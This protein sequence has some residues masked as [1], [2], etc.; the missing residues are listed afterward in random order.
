MKISVSVSTDANFGRVRKKTQ[1]YIIWAQDKIKVAGHTPK[2]MP[3]FT[4][5][6]D[7]IYGEQFAEGCN[8]SLAEEP[9]HLFAPGYLIITPAAALWLIANCSLL[10]LGLGFWPRVRRRR[11][12][13]APQLNERISSLL[14]NRA[15]QILNYAV[16][17][18]MKILSGGVIIGFDGESR[19]A[20]SIPNCFINIEG[21]HDVFNLLFHCLFY[22]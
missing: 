8:P 11:E 15:R 20:S 4:H 9:R 16:G 21:A 2:L 22:A 19:Q 6:G 12:P 14:L 1:R 10:S 5:R 17:E 3:F 18:L 7:V 13:R